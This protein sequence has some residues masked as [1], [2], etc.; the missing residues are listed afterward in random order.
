M[1]GTE[2]Y[3]SMPG[4]HSGT[5]PVP[6]TS[7]KNPRVLVI[8][9]DKLIR[10]FLKS[11]LR[12]REYETETAGDCDQAKNLL[13]EKNFDLILCDINLPGMSGSEFLPFCKTN[14][15]NTEII[16]ITGQPGI[17]DAVHAVKDGA[18]DYLPKPISPEKLYDRVK[19]ALLETARKQSL[20]DSPVAG[21]KIVRNLGAGTMGVVLLVQKENDYYAMKILRSAGDMDS[22]KNVKRFM[23]EADI[24]T[25]IDHP[26]IVKF[27]EYGLSPKENVPYFIMEFVDGNP[28]SAHIAM[29][30]LNMEEKLAVIKQIADALAFIHDRGILHRDVKPANILLTDSKNVKLT[31]FGI[32]RIAESELTITHEM[33]GTPAYMS[34]EAFDA[35]RE[36]DQRSD[37]FSLGTICYEL[38]TE[39]KPFSGE[40]IA[41][42]MDSIQHEKP[43]EPMR[44]APEIR[45]YVQDIMAKMLAKAPEDRFPSAA[46]VLKAL[47]KE[48]VET[49]GSSITRKLFRALLLRKP[50]WR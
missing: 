12:L 49:P 11:A 41:E 50:T 43:I 36:K 35:M 33:L 37:I 47:D 4:E 14:Y 46:A 21:Y 28:L 18:F 17:D 24:L 8:D 19:E 5:E 48:Y 10:A 31:D 22:A 42:L 30:D 9:D 32:A 20:D 25:T 6:D 3:I 29:G 44:V 16:L 40:T 27:F 15:P 45:P 26:N 38:L 2:R 7:P 1:S 39:I 13:A 23:R 34:P